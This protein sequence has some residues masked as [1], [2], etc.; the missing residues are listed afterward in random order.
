MK[1]TLAL[2]VGGFL[3]L[4]APAAFAVFVLLFGATTVQL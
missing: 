3:G 4:S 1:R 2:S